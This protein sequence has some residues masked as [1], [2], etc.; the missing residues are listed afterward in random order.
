M[1]TN[2]RHANKKGDHVKYVLGIPASDK[3]IAKVKELSDFVQSLNLPLEQNDRLVELMIAQM[4]AV[5]TEALSEGFKLGC[6]HAE[7]K[8]RE[9]ED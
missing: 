4:R 3:L 7:W 2:K 8:A 6:D 5:Q 9:H 1:K